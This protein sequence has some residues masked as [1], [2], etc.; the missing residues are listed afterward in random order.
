MIAFAEVVVASYSKEV[1]RQFHYKIPNDLAEKLSLGVRVLVPF[2]AGN[3]T[4]EGFVTG[5][6]NETNVP[7]NRL[8]SIVKIIDEQPVFNEELLELAKFMKEKYYTTLYQCIKCIVPSGSGYKADSLILLAAD[9]ARLT[10]SQ[11]ALVSLLFENDG[12][13]LK[14]EIENELGKSALSTINTLLQK[15]I[16]QSVD[17]GSVKD[18]SL[19]IKCVYFEDEGLD[20]YEDEATKEGLTKQQQFVVEALMQNEGISLTDLKN[21]LHISDS[22]IKTLCKKGIIKIE[23]KQVLRNTVYIKGNSETKKHALTSDQQMVISHVLRKKDRKPVLIHGVTGSGKTEIYLNL[24][25]SVLQKG[26]QAIVL[27]PEI[28][29]TPQTVNLFLQRFGEQVSVT[30]SR[31]TL[32]ERYD[33]WKKARDGLVSIMIGP[34]SAV[35][36]PFKQL[37][38]IIIDEEHENTYKSETT[39]KY[40]AKEI[41]IKRSELTG[42]LVVLGSATPSVESYYEATQGTLDLLKITERVNKRLPD[43]EVSDM[44]YELANGNKS[45]FSEELLNSLTETIGKGHQ[46]ILFL[47]RR[48]Y[49]TFVSCRRCGQVMTCDSCNV[50]YTYHKYNDVLIC[51]Y[52]GKRLKNPENC[53]TCGSRFIKHFGIGT[54]RIE[55]EVKSFFP[56]ASVLRMDSDTTTGKNSHDKILQQFREG[57]ASILIGTQMIAKGL[58]FP[59]VTLVGIVA[60]DLSLNNGDYRSAENT[61]QLLTQV[62][63]RAG[64]GEKHGKVVIQTYNPE[65]YSISYVKEAD[66]ESFFTHEIALRRQMQYPPFTKVFCVLFSG[67]SEKKVIVL[68]FKLLE[69]MKFY[70]RKGL[71]E[72]VGPA[73]ASVSKIRNSYRYKLIVKAE[74]EEKLKSFVFYC[75]DKL[76]EKEDFSGVVLNLTLN[77]I[78]LV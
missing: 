20:I 16:V 37:G 74:D 19:K 26:K 40:Y 71:F 10:K 18:L 8:K 9:N 57:K 67:A 42:A 75:I 14:S 60:A 51:H 47:N 45:I 59:N 21:Y 66:Y 41:A 23:Q 49:S 56:E 5:F 13:M 4:I 29:L 25:E 39:P 17:A 43:I 65:H 30:H 76:K 2:G 32:G 52:C 38:I 11:Q 70:N 31:Q 36:T 77:P 63:G 1:D 15:G 72:M 50:N 55:Q 35:F 46:A 24:I 61:F 22:P 73:P 78:Y 12:K 54:Q 27:V 34:R 3:K 6:C 62:S 44:R 33:Q 68:T 64:R 48:G 7:L 58:D 53:P 69:I 28:S